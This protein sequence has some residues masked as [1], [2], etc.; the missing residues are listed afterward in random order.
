LPGLPGLPVGRVV[1]LGTLTD[2][3]NPSYFVSVGTQGNAGN[4][5]NLLVIDS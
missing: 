3:S 1:E 2:A 4:P 5:C